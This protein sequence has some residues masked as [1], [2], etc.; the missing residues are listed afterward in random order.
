MKIHKPA[1]KQWRSFPL[2][3]QPYLVFVCC[4]LRWISKHGSKAVCVSLCPTSY[5]DFQTWEQGNLCVFVSDCTRLPH[6]EFIQNV[7]RA[8]PFHTHVPRSS[9]TLAFHA[10]VPRSRS[11]LT[12]HARVPRSRSTLTFHAHVPRSRSTLT[13]HAHLPRLLSTSTS[14]MKIELEGHNKGVL[15][16]GIHNKEILV[17]YFLTFPLDFFLIF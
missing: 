11:T 1:T 16:V 6:K 15:I 8:K 3:T 13:F 14:D 10:R 2:N 5:V 9:S 12:F 17:T 4:C 7:T